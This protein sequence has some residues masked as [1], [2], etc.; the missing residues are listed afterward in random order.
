MHL[1]KYVSF[2][3]DFVPNVQGCDGAQRVCLAQIDDEDDDDNDD[4]NDSGDDDNKE[5]DDQEDLIPK[6]V[7][8]PNR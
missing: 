7:S 8:C 1:V 3:I 6:S 4:D 2:Q 5:D